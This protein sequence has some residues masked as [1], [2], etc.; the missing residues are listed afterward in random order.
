MKDSDGL[1][2]ILSYAHLV[3]GMQHSKS[4][5][6]AY[7]DTVKILNS[8]VKIDAI[9]QNKNNHNIK[10]IANILVQNIG[11]KVKEVAIVITVVPATF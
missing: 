8:S 1:N 5:S 3:E 6:K 7:L 4:L 9:V 11:L 2:D 10:F